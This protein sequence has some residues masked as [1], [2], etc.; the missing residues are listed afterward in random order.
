M[1]EKALYCIP[2]ILGILAILFIGMFSLDV[3]HENEPLGRQMLGFLI[4]NIP[5]LMLTA[6]LI[7]AW[8]WEHIGGTIFIIASIAGSIIFFSYSGK[9]GAIIVMVPFLIVGILFIL[10]HQNYEAVTAKKV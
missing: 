2:R 10:H 4:H 9:T 8:K 1:K 6:I 7:V 3:F 5:A